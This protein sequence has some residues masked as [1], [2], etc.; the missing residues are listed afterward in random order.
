MPYSF[1]HYILK[2]I[3]SLISV[4]EHHTHKV[5]EN[6]ENPKGDSPKIKS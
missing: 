5:K 6:S 2:S 3:Y 1:T 4:S